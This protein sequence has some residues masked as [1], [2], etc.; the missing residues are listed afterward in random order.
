M[1]RL[2]FPGA[3]DPPLVLSSTTTISFPVLVGAPGEREIVALPEPGASTTNA[4]GLEIV[5]SGFC[6]WMDKFPGDCRLGALSDV[7][8][9]VLSEHDAAC[10]TPPTRI[11]EPGPGSDGEKLLPVTSKVKPPAVPA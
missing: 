3:P 9:C 1:F 2:T 11:M 10:G 5:P 8:H 6:S 7:M 4:S